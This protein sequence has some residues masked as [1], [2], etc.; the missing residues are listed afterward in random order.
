VLLLV[1]VINDL[2]FPNNS[3]LL[4]KAVTLGKT[5][6]ALK[7][8]CKKL[9]I[10]AIYVNDNRGK[11]RSDFPAVLAHCRRPGAPGQ[12]LVER[13]IPDTSDYVVLKPKHSAFYAI[14]LDALL[15]Y[16]KAH[17]V[18]LA[19]LTTSACILMTAGEIYIRD[20]KLYV[21]SDCVAALTRH[22][23]LNALGIMKRSFEAD[24]T[25]STR[26]GL[27]KVLH[28]THSG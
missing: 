2:D 7:R 1:D 13:V 20:L 15:S 11:W 8:R 10:P 24:T 5:V 19:G 25:P 14:P 22:D 17:T 26:L 9:R 27:K 16:L 6:A 18:I 21:P 3:T 28:R 12:P 4:K 23:H